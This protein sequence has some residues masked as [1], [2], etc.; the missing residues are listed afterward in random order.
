MAWVE[1]RIDPPLAEGLS[2]AVRWRV[3]LPRRV[4]HPAFIRA[5]ADRDVSILGFEPISQG[6]EGAFWALAAPASVT[7]EPDIVVRAA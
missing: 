7:A 6:L 2:D 3:I 5:L 1:N 4:P